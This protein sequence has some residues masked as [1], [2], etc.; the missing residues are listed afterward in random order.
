MNS[1]KSK[2]NSS[3]AL[4]SGSCS[5]VMLCLISL[6]CSFAQADKTRTGPKDSREIRKTVENS[7]VGRWKSDVATVE[8]RDNGI[9]TI[10]GQLFNYRVNGSTLTISNDQETTD[11]PFQLSD[12]TL[13]V[14]V[15]GRDVVYQRLSNKQK[16]DEEK[17]VN[18]FGGSNPPELIG[19]W[20][21]MSNVQA[22][23]GG[24]MS[25]TC[26]TLNGNGAYEYYSE[27]SSSNPNGGTGSQSSDSGRWSA[28]SSSLTA[29]SN[30]GETKNYTLEK[31]NHPKNGDPMLVVD[32][33]AYVTAYQKSPW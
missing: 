28:T 19:K 4:I 26:F 9:M 20:C 10:D 23:D 29:H 30:S 17:E 31:R 12:D 8:I 7:L 25:N 14:R 27:T 22:N 1:R 11:L 33:D 5:I 18:Q 16:G 6:G 15:Q 13:T 21:Y 3:D 2:N 24:R 32:G